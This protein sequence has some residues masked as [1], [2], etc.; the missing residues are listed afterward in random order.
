MTFKYYVIRRAICEEKPD[1]ELSAKRSFETMKKI[2]NL[3]YW[4]MF[5]FMLL[6][7]I[8]IIV[9]HFSRIDDNFIFI[10]M[11]VVITLCIFQENISE[12]IIYKYDKRQKEIEEKQKQYKEYVQKVLKL[13]NDN[14]ITDDKT[15]EC[16]K[17]ECSDRL[18]KFQEKYS[19]RNRTVSGLLIVTPLTAII[20]NIMNANYSFSNGMLFVLSCGIIFL[21]LIQVYKAIDYLVFG[22]AKD[23]YLFKVLCDLEYER[24]SL[25]VKNDS[26]TI[27]EDGI[28]QNQK[29]SPTMK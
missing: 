1:K 23:E 21:G 28:T 24:S 22:L 11:L 12:K 15:Y 16:L 8:S 10:P 27:N 6:S 14:T 19:L 3:S 5:A 13:L 26:D 4:I 29:L 18:Q 2:F 25:R 20:A 17:K 9:I 7:I